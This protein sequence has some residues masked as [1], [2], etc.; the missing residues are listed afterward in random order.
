MNDAQIFHGSIRLIQSLEIGFSRKIFLH[1][2][3]FGLAL[4]ASQGFPPRR[5]VAAP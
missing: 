1:G 3:I 4:A 5:G 2:I